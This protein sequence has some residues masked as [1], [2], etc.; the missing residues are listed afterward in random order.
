MAHAPAGA[1]PPVLSLGSL[2]P[3]PSALGFAVRGCAV[4]RLPLAVSTGALYLVPPAALVV[5]F[6]RLGE[7]ARVVEVLGGAVVVAGVL[8]LDRRPDRPAPSPARARGLRP[9]PRLSAPP[10]A[11]ARLIPHR[12]DNRAAG[13]PGRRAADGASPPRSCR[14]RHRG[15][16]VRKRAR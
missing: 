12:A 13:L 4:A 15:A 5:S 9:S 10:G 3:L 16:V 11:G 1:L 6:V 7:T 2:G 8:L 14:A